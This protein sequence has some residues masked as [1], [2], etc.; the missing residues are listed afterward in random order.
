MWTSK[1]EDN[2]EAMNEFIRRLM[3]P[4]NDN[5]AEFYENI[6]LQIPKIII[7]CFSEF[8]MCHNK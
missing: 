5:Y 4:F 2:P 1:N 8:K 6:Y 7:K 3:D